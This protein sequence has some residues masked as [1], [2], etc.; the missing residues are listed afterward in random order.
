MEK[1]DRWLGSVR[2]WDKPVAY[3][4][5]MEDPVCGQWQLDGWKELRPQAHLIE[6]NLGHYPQIEDPDRFT[7]VMKLSL[8]AIINNRP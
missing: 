8:D 5:G 2:N 7:Q 6:M 1:A 3:A 4:W